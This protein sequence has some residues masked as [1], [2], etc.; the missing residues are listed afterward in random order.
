MGLEHLR[1][2][3]LSV[4][5]TTQ[6]FRACILLLFLKPL[7]LWNKSKYTLKRSSKLQLFNFIFSDLALCYW[8]QFLPKNVHFN[9]LT[10][11]SA[12]KE[13][14]IT[15]HYFLGSKMKQSI[16]VKKIR[17]LGAF[18]FFSNWSAGDFNPTSRLEKKTKPLN[19]A[20]ERFFIIFPKK[21]SFSTFSDIFENNQLQILKSLYTFYFA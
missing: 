19:F 1:I 14:S 18:F 2:W 6:I 11:S 13:F 10:L 17:A 4:I 15:S 8:N 16:F 20:Y 12:L 5:L 21:S 3:A 7:W 9:G